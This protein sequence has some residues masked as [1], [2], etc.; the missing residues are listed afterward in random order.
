LY[1]SGTIG[2]VNVFLDHA[3]TTP[4]HPAA[5]EALIAAIDAGMADPS[6]LYGAAR[7]ARIALDDARDRIARTLGGRAEEIVFTS[8]GTESCALAVIGG[9]R[10]ARGARKPARVIVSAVEHSAVL[11]AAESLEPEGFEIVKVG[12]DHT[13]R[14]DLDALREAVAP[15][16]AVVSI[17]TANPEVGTIQPLHEA[18]EIA[19]AAGALLHTAV[20][21]IPV[22]VEGVDLLSASSHKS[23]GPPGVG[24]LWVRRGVRV[25]PMLTGD[26]RERGRRGGLENLPAITGFAAAL[27]ARAD[28]IS[29]EIPRL[30]G[31]RDAVRAGISIDDVVFHGASEALPGLVA[32]SVLYVEGEA[33]LL[34]LDAAGIAVHSGSSCTSMRDEPSH[35]LAAMGAITQGSL[36]ISFGRDSTDEDV[37]AFLDALPPVVAR[38]RALV[39]G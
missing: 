7:R 29:D 24:L 28:E 34:G 1:D 19:H 35:V 14:V 30:R 9:A 12:V 18:A 20:G 21:H 8:G 22:S 6:R 10:A 17:Q 39:R 36:R 15:G 32:F 11:R 13:G 4:L 31:F 27:T 38:A 25:R 2:R 33:L 3:S 23:Y 5:R 37:R 26:E 16:A